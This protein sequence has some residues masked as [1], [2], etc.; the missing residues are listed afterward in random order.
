MSLPIGNAN[1][2]FR[3]LIIYLVVIALVTMF[4]LDLALVVVVVRPVSRM[5][6]AADEISKGNLEVEELP[7]KGKDEISVLARSFNRMYVSISKAI[8]M[9]EAGD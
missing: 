3:S 8:R 4:M 6:K 2:A 9:L 7:V 1:R 5:A